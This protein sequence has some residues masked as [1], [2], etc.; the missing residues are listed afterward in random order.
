MSTTRPF[1]DMSSFTL[2]AQAIRVL[3]TYRNE[4]R[5]A[6]NGPADSHPDKD[7]FV[8]E[9]DDGAVTTYLNQKPL[10]SHPNR[11]NLYANPEMNFSVRSEGA[12]S[13][14]TLCRFAQE[15]GNYQSFEFVSIHRSGEGNYTGSLLTGN[16]YSNSP[17]YKETLS[18]EESELQF[19]L[20]EP[21]IQGNPP[22][23]PTAPAEVKPSVDPTHQPT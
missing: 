5:N 14:T 11:D 6:D 2:S 15:A 17:L 19:R 7:V 1:P 16:N 4:L 22:V 13:G 21:V 3:T 9:Y 12:L 10:V 18:P 8:L 20:Y 23:K